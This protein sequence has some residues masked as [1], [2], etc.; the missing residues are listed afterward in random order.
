MF[1][2]QPKPREDSIVSSV[3]DKIQAQSKD[4]NEAHEAFTAGQAAE[5]NDDLEGAISAY[6]AC[7]AAWEQYM[8]TTGHAVPPEPYMRLGILFR[9]I[10][11]I[12][13]EIRVLESYMAH[14]GRDP[15]GR[16]G[17]RLQRAYEL[18]E[19]D[20]EEMED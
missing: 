18:A 20:E 6:L 1:K 7:A 16:I 12:N 14:A 4:Q 19:P 5:A 15:D 13:M 10:K 11:E 8:Q 2:R 17:E 3:M 9:K